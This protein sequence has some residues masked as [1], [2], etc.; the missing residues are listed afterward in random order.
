[1]DNSSP[2]FEASSDPS[3]AAGSRSGL[4]DV[5][6]HFTRHIAPSYHHER[7]ERSLQ[8]R[9]YTMQKGQHLL[10][11]IMFACLF[12]IAVLMGMAGPRITA[13]H[14]ESTGAGPVD[15]EGPHLVV[16]PALGAYRRQLWLAAEVRIA[17]QDGG[18]TFTKRHK[19]ATQV[20]REN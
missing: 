6:S 12:L 18:S 3:S 13:D 10:M 16:T 11:A 1:M 20:R 17:D 9:L 15:P 4:S 19:I 2:L 5:F 8:M 7:P 14:R